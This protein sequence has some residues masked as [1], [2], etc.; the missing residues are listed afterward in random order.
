MADMVEPKI[1]QPRVSQHRLGSSPTAATLH[2]PHYHRSTSPRCNKD[3]RG[4][5]RVEQ[6][7]LIPLARSAW[8]LTSPRRG[9]SNNR[10]SILGYVSVDHAGCA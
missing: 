10:Q 5:R 8:A 7:L 1:A 9:Q 6:M 4:K 3:W 2:A